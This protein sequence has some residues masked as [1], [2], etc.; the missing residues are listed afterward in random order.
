MRAKIRR[1]HQLTAANRAV[2]VDLQEW[3]EETFRM[4]R[5][6]LWPVLEPNLLSHFIAEK[7]LGKSCFVYFAVRRELIVFCREFIMFCRELIMF[8]REFIFIL[9]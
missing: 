7:A 3:R 1:F 5:E 4:S 9:P 8:C 2:H 6:L